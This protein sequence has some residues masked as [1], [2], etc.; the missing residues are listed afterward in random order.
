MVLYYAEGGSFNNWMKISYGWRSDMKTLNNIIVGFVK[1]HEKN[2]VYRD[3][4]IGN[5][6]LR[7]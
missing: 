3:F 5:I 7:S 2:R 4:H 1:I 6:S